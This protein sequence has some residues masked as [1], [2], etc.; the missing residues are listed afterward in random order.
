M[1][2]KSDELFLV[3]PQGYR[4][5]STSVW[6]KYNTKAYRRR[7]GELDEDGEEYDSDEFDHYDLF[8]SPDERVSGKEMET[9]PVH[10]RA[11]GKA[12]SKK[13]DN[14]VTKCAA[15]LF[16]VQF[17]TP[18]SPP[19]NTDQN[20]ANLILRR[21][22]CSSLCVYSRKS[23]ATAPFTIDSS[24]TARSRSLCSSKTGSCPLPGMCVRGR[25]R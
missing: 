3:E 12:P 20:N 9:T 8:A 18:H 14:V 16:A 10:P 21:T 24:L 13:N 1:R 17:V 7:I 19:H 2:C 25:A 15:E 4:M 22:P 23:A 11:D 5:T 6:G